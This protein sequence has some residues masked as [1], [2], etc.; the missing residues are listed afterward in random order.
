MVQQ[1][2]TSK[3]TIIRKLVAGLSIDFLNHQEY[4]VAGDDAIVRRASRA[5]AE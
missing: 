5:Y 2:K 3:M 1:Q 4:L